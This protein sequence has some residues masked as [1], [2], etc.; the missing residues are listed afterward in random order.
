MPAKTDDKAM[1]AVFAQPDHLFQALY[2][3]AGQQQRFFPHEVTAVDGGGWALPVTICGDRQQFEHLTRQY[4][5]VVTVVN[6]PPAGKGIALWKCLEGAWAWTYHDP[7]K[8]RQAYESFSAET[9]WHS[10]RIPVS[11]LEETIRCLLGARDQAQAQVVLAVLTEVF[12]MGIRAVPIVPR[13]ISPDSG[14]SFFWDV[15]MDDLMPVVLRAADRAWWRL[16]SSGPIEIYQEWPYTL[17]LPKACLSKIDWGLTSGFV[18]LSRNE[19]QIIVLEVPKGQ[20]SFR[21]I[22]DIARPEVGEHRTLQMRSDPVGESPLK[23]QFQLKL[24]KEDR[25]YSLLNRAR[26]LEAEIETR[27]K[28]LDSIREELRP[29]EDQQAAPQPLFLYHGAESDFPYQLR[30]LL[31]DWSDQPEDLCAL[32]YMKL[33]SA[34]LPVG[35]FPDHRVIHILTVATAIG[36]RGGPDLGLRLQEYAPEGPYSWFDLMPGWARLDLHLFVPRGHRP[37][38]YPPIR[39]SRTAADK[40]AAE[41]LPARTGWAA[42][43]VP[44]LDNKLRVLQVRLADLQPLLASFQWDCGLGSSCDPLYA[45][46][47]LSRQIIRQIVTTVDGDLTRDL[48]GEVTRRQDEVLDR[49]NGQLQAI[50]NVTTRH[51]KAIS[52][53]ETMTETYDGLHRQLDAAVKATIKQGQTFSHDVTQV[54]TTLRRME[55]KL[56]GIDRIKADIDAMN[57]Q[58]TFWARVLDRL[59]RFRQRIQGDSAVEQEN[60]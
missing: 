50:E 35:F 24:V 30:R 33:D 17:W 44:A 2:L 47:E 7:C 6:G 12:A 39:P 21:E 13:F 45:A 8:I 36:E 23:F 41:L 4:E 43:L 3:C 60:R 46:N 29:E 10:L 11:P 20:P 5:W 58:A 18:L 16:G 56:N 48:Q 34:R 22:I 9:T 59:R 31:L 38:L 53:L 15:S 26:E 28:A 32:R 27:Q 25:H 49:L 37:E 57:A 52:N 14:F 55:G 42:L 1:Y 40:L 19:P 51:T 54:R